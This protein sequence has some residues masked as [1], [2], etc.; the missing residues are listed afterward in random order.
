MDLI[1]FTLMGLA[2][3]EVRQILSFCDK[4]LRG[5]MNEKVSLSGA[6]EDLES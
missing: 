5:V 4:N 6:L 3:V 2:L 1:I